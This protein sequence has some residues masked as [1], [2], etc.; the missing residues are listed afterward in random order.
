MFFFEKAIE[1]IKPTVLES[2]DGKTFEIGNHKLQSFKMDHA[3]CDAY[4]FK[5]TKDVDSIAFTGD[6]AMCDN[7]IKLIDGTKIAF[8]DTTGAPPPNTKPLHFD[9]PDFEKLKEQVT[10]VR[11]IP[12]HMS[13]ETRQKMED[14]GFETPNDNDVFEI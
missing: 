5:I 1:N 9:I 4:G 10:G 14:L 3:N 8:I 2:S 11:L 7:I 13:D 6:S 12:V